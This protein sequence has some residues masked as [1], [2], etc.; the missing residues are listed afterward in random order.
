MFGEIV[1]QYKERRK[2]DLPI[3][4]IEY[5]LG[6]CLYVL[7]LIEDEKGLF[8]NLKDHRLHPDHSSKILDL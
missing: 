6:C 3:N 2:E 5:Q 8:H 7:N 4:R 1:H